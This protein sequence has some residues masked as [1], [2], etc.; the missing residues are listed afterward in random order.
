MNNGKHTAETYKRTFFLYVYRAT[1]QKYFWQKCGFVYYFY[2]IRKRLFIKTTTLALRFFEILN[3]RNLSN[4]QLCE[5][6]I[7]DLLFLYI[8]ERGNTKMSHYEV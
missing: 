3:S 6:V 4:K 2:L 7:E 5:E 1:V 8:F